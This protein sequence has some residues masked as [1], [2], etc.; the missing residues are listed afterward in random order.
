MKKFLTLFV[1]VFILMTV[2]CHS[3]KTTPDNTVLL[4][5]NF[6]IPDGY[7]NAIEKKYNVKKKM[8]NIGADYM[9]DIVTLEKDAGNSTIKS[10]KVTLN[11]GVK[12]YEI[13][14]SASDLRPI[15]PGSTKQNL[16]VYSDVAV[17]YHI[18]GLK[19]QSSEV[20]YFKVNS[21][22]EANE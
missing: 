20:K 16:K 21:L 14:A 9:F 3:S 6:K 2:S 15:I 10:I 4:D 22:G 11:K 12:N 1:F 17:M 7:S 5:K 8:D 18:E 19:G 13:E